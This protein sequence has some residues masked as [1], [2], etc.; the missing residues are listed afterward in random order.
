MTNLSVYSLVFIGCTEEEIAPPFVSLDA[1]YTVAEDE[2][3]KVSH[4]CRGSGLWPEDA[5]GYT[6]AFYPRKSDLL[7]TWVAGGLNESR[8]TGA[9]GLFRPFG[10][11]LV[12]TCDV[13]RAL[14]VASA[15]PPSVS[16]Q[17]PAFLLF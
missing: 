14:A 1:N 15:R 8:R 16:V 12:F 2:Q 13:Q 17:T 9:A 3:E 5:Q 4:V 6:P 10:R 7:K 11:L